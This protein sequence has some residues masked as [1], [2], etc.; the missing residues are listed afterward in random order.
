[1]EMNFNAVG[2]MIA[3][4][5]IISVR[6]RMGGRVFGGLRFELTGPLRQVGIWARLL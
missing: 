3:V 2:G 5:M 6:S 1:M 4:P